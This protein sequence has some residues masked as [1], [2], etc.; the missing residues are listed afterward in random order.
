MPS[1]NAQDASGAIPAGEYEAIIASVEDGYSK[2]GNEM[3]I[4]A[5]T[6]YTDRGERTIKEYFTFG[7]GALWKYRKVAEALGAR[8]DFDNEQ[9][10]VSEYIN[11]GLIVELEVEED[12]EFGD[13][14]RV[15]KYLPPKRSG[16][17]PQKSSKPNATVPDDDD[18]DS[19][20][21]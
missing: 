18:P 9:F 12:P 7:P 17:K 8:D 10:D 16:G 5:F 1:Y 2:Q 6:V 21:F 19:I 11:A 20:P 4:V 14:N 13:K 15:M 3:Q